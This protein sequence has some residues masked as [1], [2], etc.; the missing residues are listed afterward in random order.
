[1]QRGPIKVLCM[2]LAGGEGRRLYPLT[3]DRAK[4]AVPFAGRYRII[5]IVLSNL[6]N[7]GLN[8]IKVVTQY[9]SHSLETHVARAWRVASIL[10]QYIEPIPAQQRTGKSW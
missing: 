6:V 5:D 7:S 2:V 8:K 3:I 1:M 9:K 4:P 10:D